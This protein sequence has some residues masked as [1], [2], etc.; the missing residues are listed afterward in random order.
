MVGT[1]EKDRHQLAFNTISF[2]LIVHLPTLS[3]LSYLAH[4][5]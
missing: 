1:L 5:Q 2:L 3:N 4:S